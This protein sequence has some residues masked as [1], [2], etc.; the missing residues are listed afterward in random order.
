MIRTVITLSCLLAVIAVTAA[1][2]AARTTA[3]TEN[4]RVVILER[5]GTWTYEGSAGPDSAVTSTDGHTFRQTTWGMSPAEVIAAEGKD[6]DAT[7]DGMLF[8]GDTV[9]GSD[10]VAVYIFVEDKLVRAAYV[11]DESYTN[12]NNYIREYRKFLD[13]LTQKYGAPEKEDTYWSQE[14]FRDNP[15]NYGTALQMGHAVW[16]ASWSTS[17]SDVL[18]QLSGGN[19][20][21][22]LKIQYVS[23]GLKHLEEQARQKDAAESL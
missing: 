8:Y 17:R 22:T 14:M 10:V 4:G 6:P 12:A 19:Y 9:G 11:S 18:L 21:A 7:Q 16:E 20:E 3:T 23:K 2:A 13:L 15:S 1:P 5:D